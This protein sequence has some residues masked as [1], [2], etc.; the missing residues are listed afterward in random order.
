VAPKKKVPAAVGAGSEEASSGED[1]PE[2]EPGA[3]AP[4]DDGK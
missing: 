3:D 4:A 1:Q 2:I